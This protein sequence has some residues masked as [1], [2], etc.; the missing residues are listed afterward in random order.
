MH[1]Y[2]AI[3]IVGPTASGK[4]AAAISLAKYFNTAVISADSRQCYREMTIGTAKPSLDELKEVPH[5]FINSHSIT[6]EVNAAI[7]EQFALSYCK[8][9]FQKSKIAILCGGTGLY[10]KAFCQGIDKIPLI[11]AIVR[12]QVQNN[13]EEKGLK[14]LQQEVEQ[15]DPV[16]F[17]SSEKK[18]PHRLMRALEVK[19]STGESVLNFRSEK[20][21][22]RN[23]NII[24][25]G[26]SVPKEELNKRIRLRTDQMITDGLIKEVKTLFP[27]RNNQAL[28]T[29]GYREIFEY[30]DGKLTPEEAAE[31]IKIHTRQYAKRQMTW[32]RKDAS[33]HWLKD[34]SLPSMLS[35][36]Q[37][38]LNIK[39]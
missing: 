13:Y 18:N 11:P 15:R 36:L 16:F 28:Q 17:A 30:L 23:F 37:P 20:N 7:Y 22:P 31:K 25:I 5:Y 32:F 3:V 27:F 33:I 8:K 38:L 14:W 10:V 12:N 9:I 24:K 29:V 4:T 39:I 2:S 19:L 21:K 6:E 26:L 35:C 1:E 34:S